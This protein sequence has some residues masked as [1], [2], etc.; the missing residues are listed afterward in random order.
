[1]GVGAF[2]FEFVFV[3]GHDCYIVIF[4]FCFWSHSRKQSPHTAW[5]SGSSSSFQRV[6]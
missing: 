3:F 2:C 4:A 1:M 5:F 6:V